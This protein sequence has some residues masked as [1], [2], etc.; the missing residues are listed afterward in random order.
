MPAQAHLYAKLVQDAMLH[1]ISSG[2]F[3]VHDD[4]YSA[5]EQSHAVDAAATVTAEAAATQAM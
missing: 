1:S 5:Q 3:L 2:F 4:S